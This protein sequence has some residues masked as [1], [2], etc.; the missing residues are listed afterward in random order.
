MWHLPV[1]KLRSVGCHLCQTLQIQKSLPRSIYG[2]QRR[3]ADQVSQ[4]MP[5]STH[6]T[7]LSL[8]LRVWPSFRLSLSLSWLSSLPVPYLASDHRIGSS[9]SPTDDHK[10]ENI[11]FLDILCDIRRNR[12][13]E[14]PPAALS[15]SGT[16]AAGVERYFFYISLL[17]TAQ[18]V[19]VTVI[20]TKHRELAHFIFVLFKQDKFDK[21]RF[22]QVPVR[23]SVRT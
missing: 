5:I 6:N 8:S 16:G 1:R 18:P 20:L 11:N 12:S 10:K 17:H 22:K 14:R 4:R 7:S 19:W 3:A 13:Q 2:E 15:T 23:T 21:V 9:L